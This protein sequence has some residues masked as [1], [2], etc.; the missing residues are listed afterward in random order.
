MDTLPTASGNPAGQ[1][2]WAPPSPGTIRRHAPRPS[3]PSQ[4]QQSSGSTL[5]DLTSPL[6]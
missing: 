3:S 5:Y 1:S 2:L 4:S 6:S